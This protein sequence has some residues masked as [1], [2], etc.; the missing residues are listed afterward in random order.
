VIKDEYIVGHTVH[1]C[2][3]VK[4]RQ[5]CVWLRRSELLRKHGTHCRTISDAA[6]WVL[7]HLNDI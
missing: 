5:T 1:S 2:E 4:N 6:N 7:K 3:E